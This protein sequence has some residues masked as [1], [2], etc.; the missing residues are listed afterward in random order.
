MRPF[1]SEADAP[2]SVP[3]PAAVEIVTK[4]GSTT[5]RRTEVAFHNLPHSL[6]LH[7]DIAMNQAVTEPS[8][9][10]PRDLWVSRLGIL[11]EE[12]GRL[13]ER[14]ESVHSRISKVCISPQALDV[15]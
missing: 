5:S 15:A 10:R 6:E 8:D 12:V 7:V 14:L 4:F 9:T 1:A 2:A 3:F 13:G 11:R